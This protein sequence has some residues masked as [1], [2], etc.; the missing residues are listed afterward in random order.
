MASEDKP[1]TGWLNIAVDYGPLIVFLA[2]YKLASPDGD[3]PLGQIAAQSGGADDMGGA[4]LG[5]QRGMLDRGLG[6]GEIGGAL[7]QHRT[8]GQEFQRRGVGRRFGLDEHGVLL[9]LSYGP[10]PAFGQAP[11]PRQMRQW[12]VRKSPPAGR[13]TYRRGS[14]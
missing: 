5:G 13:A 11:C 3:A 2:V 4:C 1:R 14:A 9:S 10:A 8:A 12:L 7:I 6:R